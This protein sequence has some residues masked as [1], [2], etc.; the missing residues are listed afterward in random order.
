MTKLFRVKLMFA[1]KEELTSSGEPQ[2]T[3][4]ALLGYIKLDLQKACQAETR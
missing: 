3:L 1:I 4:L 2:G